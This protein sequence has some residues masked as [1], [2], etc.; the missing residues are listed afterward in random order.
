MAPWIVKPAYCSHDQ[1]FENVDMKSK[2]LQGRA[3]R[4]NAS[5]VI[6]GFIMMCAGFYLLLQSIVVTQS[7]FLGVGL[8]HLSFGGG[9]SITSGMILVPLIFGIGM[10]FY[11]TSS[12]LG[13]ALAI[14]SLSALVIGVMVNTHFALRSM[15]L[16]EM[17][18]IFVLAIGGLG[19]F[20]RGV[21]NG[22]KSL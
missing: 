22:K 9:T 15:S 11:N 10:V 20:L 19:L 14:G 17:L 4:G 6:L 7:Y 8:Y 1:S 5:N 3:Q 21:Y 12:L 18:G 13:W 2:T 16:F